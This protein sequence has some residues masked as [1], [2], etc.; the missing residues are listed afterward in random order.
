LAIVEICFKDSMPNYLR[1]GKTW[2]SD[3]GLYYNIRKVDSE[4][5]RCSGLPTQYNGVKGCR[6][7]L[8]VSYFT[9]V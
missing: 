3:N 1:N 8:R 4:N 5:R 2:T 6:T 9:K 7:I